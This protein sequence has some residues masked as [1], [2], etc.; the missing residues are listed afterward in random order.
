M[1]QPEA[2]PR[3]RKIVLLL[4]TLPLFA[5]LLTYDMVVPFLPGYVRT[6]GVSDV[7][8]AFLFGAY[9]AALLLALPVAGWW[10]DRISRRGLVLFGIVGLAASSLLQGCSESYA[11]MFVARL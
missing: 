10:C 9:P 1:P 5:D 8:I 2:S 6:W 7:G 4:V 3:S 11:L